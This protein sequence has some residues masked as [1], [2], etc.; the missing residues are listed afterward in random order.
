MEQKQK[1]KQFKGQ[2]RYPNLPFTLNLIY[3]LCE[4]GVDAR[5]PI[6]C[7]D[8]PALKATFRI[9]KDVPLELAALSNMPIVDFESP[10]MS[11]YLVAVVIGVFTHFEDRK[12]D[13]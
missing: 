12:A 7:R 9:T 4:W 6:P 5:R 2:T 8:E 10:L 13:V 11:S 3:Y 1:I